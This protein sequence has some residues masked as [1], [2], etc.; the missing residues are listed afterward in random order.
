MDYYEVYSHYYSVTIRI[1]QQD[2]NQRKSRPGL[3]ERPW[4]VPQCDDA[5]QCPEGLE[6]ADK[7][8][9]ADL[10]AQPGDAQK[11]EDAGHGVRDR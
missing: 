6:H 8:P 1:T 2:G 3:R 10:F 7:G 9:L 11:S 5:R 4:P